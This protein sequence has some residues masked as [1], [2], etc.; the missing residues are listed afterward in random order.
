VIAGA[1]YQP[2][3]QLRVYAETLNIRGGPGTGFDFVRG[4]LVTGEYV[5]ILAGPVEAEGITWWQVQ[6]ADGAIGWI[7]GAIGGV[8]TLGP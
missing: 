1:I 3:Q 6:T 2:G 8:A 5:A 7:A 4:F